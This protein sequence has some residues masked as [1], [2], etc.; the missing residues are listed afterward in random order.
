MRKINRHVGVSMK[1][2]KIWVDT[3]KTGYDEFDSA[4]VV[5][6]SKEE[7]LSHFVY[8]TMSGDIVWHFYKDINDQRQSD[9]WFCG[10]QGTINIEEVPLDKLDVICTSFN[11]G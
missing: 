2:Y 6:N 5:A 4:I 3:D 8:D 7:I 10:H 1:V 11:A 9:F